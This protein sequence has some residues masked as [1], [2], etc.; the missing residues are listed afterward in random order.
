M[1]DSNG[2]LNHAVVDAVDPGPMTV[3]GSI[4]HNSQVML[5]CTNGGITVEGKI[6]GSSVVYLVSTGPIV[7]NGKIDGSATVV[8][9][10]TGGSITIG[11]KVDGSSDVSLEAAGD[12]AIGTIGVVEDKKI[13]GS[14]GVTASAGGNV[15]IGSYVHASSVDFK[16]RGSIHSDGFDNAANVRYLADGDVGVR[17]AIDGA[18]RI[19]LV[20][21]RGSIAVDGKVDGSSKVFLSA[22][23]D[24]GIGVGP[25][26][27][28]ED[29]KIDG[30]SSVTAIAGGDIRLGSRIAKDHT[31]VDFAAGGAVVIGGEIGFKATAR[32][33]SA[34]Q[35]IDIVGGVNGGSTVTTAPAG[36]ANP[37]VSGGAQWLQ[38]DWAEPAG[39]LPTPGRAGYWW[40]NWGQTFGYV[41]PF[42]VVPRSLDDIV[43]AVAGSATP[44]RPDA[45]PVKAVGGGWSFTDAALPFMTPEEVTRASLLERGKWQRQDMR[46]VLQGVTSDL[47]SGKIDLYP[48]PMDLA[49]EMVGRNLPFSTAYDQTALRQVTSSG[50]QL[51]ASSE[52][53]LIDTRSLASSLQCD[54]PAIRS[55]ASRR[56]RHPEILFHVEAGITM[57]DL[58]QLL[59][60]QHPRL[61]IAASGGSPGATLA[62][63]LA[64]A[65]HGGEFNTPLLIDC[66]RAVHLVGPG[67]EQW[68]IEGAIPVADQVKLQQHG[69]PLIDAA[70]FIGGKWAGIP[71]LTAQDVLDAVV[72]SIGTIGVVYSMVLAVQPQFGLHQVVHPTTWGELLASAQVSENDLRAGSI[73][74]NEALLGALIDG[75]VNGTGIDKTKNRYI[76]L[77]INPL[78]LDCWIVN[79]ELTAQLPDDGNSPGPGLGDYQTM[80]TRLLGQ[81][82]KDSAL[83]SMLLGRVFDFF[84]WG[85]DPF[86]LMLHDPGRI[87]HL[88]GFL[89]R[90]PDLVGDLLAIINAQTAVNEVNE[91]SSPDR[92]QQ[93][94]ADVLTSFFHA[95]EGT[96]PGQNSDHTGV[97]YHVGAIGWPDGGMPGRGL[98]IALDQTNAFTFLQ[99]VLLDD[100]LVATMADLFNPMLGYVSVR[101]CPPTRTLLGMQQYAPRS[102]M[103]EVVAYRSPQANAV[104]QAIAAK[105]VSWSGPG[106]K[107]LL[108]WG[109]ENDFVDQAFLSGTPLGQPY[110]G[111]PTR[112]AAFHEVREYLRNGHPQVFDNAF[113][114]RIGV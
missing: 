21:N 17:G 74:A 103:I 41:A 80:L 18:S 15:S 101:V 104:M 31:T 75:T 60:H 92:G 93:F 44:G 114:A 94:L 46:D 8:L 87:T 73:P 38:D 5:R 12:I 86:T 35:K 59:D 39:F 67:G 34:A 50:V 33:L 10:S 24:V 66:V 111:F 1:W 69:Y 83:G 53:V 42:R 96:R 77:A 90:Y 110:K 68:W 97:S 55:T 11:G 112:L 84:G 28:D 61:A 51:P 58:Q 89:P 108:H 48:T 85:L 3:S 71:G 102:V 54:F 109:L 27:N 32:L 30:D 23:R 2:D 26:G 52:V 63:A 45:R 65:T 105:T 79:R 107:P 29:H 4:D 56:R 9:V 40:E 88:L 43:A 70:H 37:T 98:E 82:S 49:P 47:L 64:T 57:A 19:E 20:S 106:P 36:A 113:S 72:V 100:V 62:G 81:Q 6:D 13:D 78:N 14:S 25:L 99:Q 76:D 95:L 22:G 7:V 91:S 16:A